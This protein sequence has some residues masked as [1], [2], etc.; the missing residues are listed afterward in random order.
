MWKCPKCS[1]QVEDDFDVCWNCQTG[2]D[3]SSAETYFAPAAPKTTAHTD[4][5]TKETDETGWRWRYSAWTGIMYGP[6]PV[7]IIVVVIVYLVYRIL[8]AT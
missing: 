3:G 4:A 5:G 6:I 8:S 2:K 7:G 1:E